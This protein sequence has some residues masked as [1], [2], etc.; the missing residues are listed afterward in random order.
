MFQLLDG[1][2]YVFVWRTV[3]ACPVVRA[4]GKAQGPARE[5]LWVCEVAGTLPSTLDVKPRRDG[6]MRDHETLFNEWGCYYF[7]LIL[8]RELCFSVPVDMQCYVSDVSVGIRRP[9]VDSTALLSSPVTSP[10][11]HPNRRGHWFSAREH[12]AVGLYFVRLSRS[13]SC[14]LG[15]SRMPFA[16][17]FVLHLCVWT[18][19]ANVD[20]P[21]ACS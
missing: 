17:Q 13:S 8:S 18:E 2:E 4:E 9:C 7:F 15:F 12:L 3:E 19:W 16:R 14:D 6:H 20:M 10:A 21:N 1:C 11:C 5:R